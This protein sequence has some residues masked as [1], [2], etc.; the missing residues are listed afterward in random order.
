MIEECV[1]N[2]LKYKNHFFVCL[3]SEVLRLHT[4]H[5]N[6]FCRILTLKSHWNDFA[7]NLFKKNV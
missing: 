1:K 4:N 3:A 2:V 5:F 6:T 7:Q